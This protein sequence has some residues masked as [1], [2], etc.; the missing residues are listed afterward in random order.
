MGL[1]TWVNNK[2]CEHGSYSL[3]TQIYFK[4]LL[5]MQK[6]SLN[7]LVYHVSHLTKVLHNTLTELYKIIQ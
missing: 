3:M 2:T 5:Q 7:A 4:Y 6:T 1:V